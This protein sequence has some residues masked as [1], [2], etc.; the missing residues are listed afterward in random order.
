M[1]RGVKPLRTPRAVRPKRRPTPPRASGAGAVPAASAIGVDT[2]GTFTDFVAIVGGRRVA[3]KLPSTPAAPERAVLAGLERLGAGTHTRVR[4]GSTVATNALLERKGAR[5]LFVTTRGFEDLLEIGRQERPEL[6]ALDPRR[7]PPLVP[8]ARRLGVRERIGSKGETLTPLTAKELVRVARAARRARAESIAIGLLHA[9]AHPGHER[10]L[11]R[12][13]A[14]SGLPITRSSKLCPEIR[15]YERFATTVTNAYLMPRVGAYLGALA[16][17][18]RAGLEVVL[19]HGGTAPPAAAAREPVRQLLSGPAAGLR[20][21]RAAAVGCGFPRALT[22][23]VGGTSTDCAYVAG[24]LPRRRARE[25]AGFPVL[26]PVLDVHTVGAGGGSVASVDAGGLLRVGPGSAGADPGPACYGRGG[27]ITVTDALVLLGRIAGETLA[28]GALTLDREAA[29]AALE[30][31]AR[32]LGTRDAV[33]AAEG[34]VAVADARMEAALRRVS[35]ERGH[36]PRDAALVAFGG[37][38]GLH[39]CALAAALDCEAVVF[40][41]AAGVLSALGALAGGS[42]RERSRSVLRDARDGA[43]FERDFARLERGVRGEFAV[44]E[45]RGVTLERWCQARYAG[46]SHELEIA[47]SADVV[48]RF[49]AAHASRFGFAEP[50]AQVEIVTLEVRGTRPADPVPAARHRPAAPRTRAIARVRD[51]GAWH[52]AAVV[53]RATL[54]RGERLRG[55]AIV[56]DDGA[57]LWIAPGWTAVVHTSEALVLRRGRDR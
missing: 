50:G 52:R 30:R 1:K 51:G 25:V 17:G 46:Q 42:R 45:R 43:S 19:S 10:R 22:L 47:W 48:A 2:G 16:R 24:E 13:L 9:W 3:F 57:T 6:Y 7:M 12:A 55:P 29:A 36:D 27:P 38:G 37:A 54:A 14:G 53:Q 49:H 15:E 26:L 32:A 39:A 21:A 35:V 23:D 31:L 11:E 41:A 56:T 33:A 4:H 18:T 44:H 20:A 8:R 34:V 28:G 5:V 40:P